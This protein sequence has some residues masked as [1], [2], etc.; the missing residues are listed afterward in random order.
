M[1]YE[2][3]DFASKDVNIG[4]CRLVDDGETLQLQ[5]AFAEE[6]QIKRTAVDCPFGTSL[7]FQ[8]L[9]IC[10]MQMPIS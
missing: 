6:E 4:R 1:L 10:A 2:G 8:Q 7:G 9:L 3:I 5:L